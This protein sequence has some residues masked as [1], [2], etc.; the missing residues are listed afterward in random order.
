MSSPPT[1]AQSYGHFLESVVYGIY[2]VTCVSCIRPL[3]LNQR[4][5]RRAS[6][7]NLGMVIVACLFFSIA[8]IDVVLQFYWTLRTFATTEGPVAAAVKFSD[9]S[10]PI[11]V[12]KTV[13]VRL[14]ISLADGMLVYHCWIIYNR[15]WMVIIVPLVL[16]L[17]GIAITGVLIYMDITLKLHA[18]LSVVQRKPFSAAFWGMTITINLLTTALIVAQIYRI[19]RSAKEFRYMSESQRRRPPSKLQ[20]A[21][22]VIVESGLMY[23]VTAILTF[24]TYVTNNVAVYV[25]TDLRVQV[26][27]IAFNLIIIRAARLDSADVTSSTAPRNSYPLQFIS[28][29]SQPSAVCISTQEDVIVTREDDAGSQ[30]GDEAKIL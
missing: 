17:A 13:T 7:I 23:A 1:D 24:G 19:D 12:I 11:N 8:T 21:I 20:H 16:W 28:A 14:Q 27:G 29:T 3:C 4:G 15:S 2:L 5:W 25:T 10:N 6:E 26:I 9:I 22:R 18:L 30:N